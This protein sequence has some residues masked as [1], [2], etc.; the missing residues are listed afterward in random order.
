MAAM[1]RTIKH[2]LRAAS[3]LV[4]FTILGLALMLAACAGRTPAP[5]PG[6]AVPTPTLAPLD[7]PTPTGPLTL[8]FWE[9][10]GE[11]AGV[12]LDELTAAF[13]RANP[14]ITITRTH[15]SYDD[16][17]NQ[18]RD[19]IE[20]LANGFLRADGSGELTRQLLS[21]PDLCRQ[22]WDEVLHIIYRLLFLL[23]AEQRGMVPRAG[24]PL[25]ELYR[26]QYS[27][28]ALRALAEGEIPRE[29]D[30]ADLWAGLLVTFRLV[31]EGAPE[32]GVFAYDGMLLSLIHISE[33]TRL[34]S[35]SYAVFCLKKK[36]ILPNVNSFD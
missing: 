23:L 24:A 14:G 3:L 5:T 7:L 20:T 36:N 6:P 19:A 17:R 32:L 27:L 34:L 35:I 25:E 21:S 22:F 28:T 33:P 13:M 30:Y 29:E 8:T 31:S 1:H 12:L 16:L 15:F 9:D 26:S 18:V 4:T 10:D 11:A 2:L